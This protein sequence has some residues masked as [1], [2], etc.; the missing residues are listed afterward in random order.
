MKLNRKIL[1][2]TISILFVSLLISS[3]ALV[4]NFKKNYTE[5]LLS[6]S[7]GLGQ[8]LNS[9]VTELLNLGLPLDSFAGI[10]RK[11]RQLIA[12]NPHITY[13]G[14]TDPSGKVLYNGDPALVGHVFSDEV[15]ARSVASPTPI[16]Q[17]YHRFDGH[18]YYDVTIPIFDSAH[19]R[20][21]QIR[22]GFPISV[23]NDKILAALLQVVVNFSLSFV[24]IAVLINFFMS[25]FV[26]RPVIRI[27]EHA[28]KIADGN[29]D[30]EL[31]VTSDDEVGLLAGS[32]NQM[33]SQVKQKTR[34]L[35]AANAELQ[36]KLVERQRAEASLRASEEKFRTFVENSFDVIFVLDPAGV[37][38]FASPS[39]HKH[40]GFPASEVVGCDFRPF[41]HPDDAAPCVE[42]L[43]N[44]MATG[45][46]ATSPPY[47]VRHADGSWRLFIANG[48]CYTDPNGV[49]L[50]V[51][52]GRDI[53]DQKRAEEERLSLERNLL[54]T[55]KLESLG[56]LAG[57]I[58]HDFNNLLAAILGNLDLT[59]FRL[60]PASP[61]VAGITRAI[62][63]C[64]RASDLTQQM[65]AYSGKGVFQL[66]EI[67]LGRVVEENLELLRTT[68]PKAI[69]LTLD[70][71]N[72]L[73]LVNADPGQIQQVV[74]N[75]ITNASEAIGDAP[76]T[77]VVTTGVRECDESLLKRS[78]LPEKP[79][80]GRYASIEVSDSGC[81]MDQE[82]Q[83]R[84]FEPFFTTKFT[85][86]GLGM[87]AILGIIKAHNGA[88][89]MESEP[90]R[91]TTFTVLLPVSTEDRGIPREEAAPQ[92]PAEARPGFTGTVLVVDDE[93]VVREICVDYAGSF[94]FDTLSASDGVEAVELFRQHADA[95]VLVILDLTMPRMDGVATFRELKR[96]RPSVK[97]IASSGYA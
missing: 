67:D 16:T 22:L 54:H 63:A 75:L 94:G 66:K 73:P 40:F 45:Q 36:L 5:A 43:K 3:V 15:M 48:T 29:Y 35:E 78:R 64:R 92:E 27:S 50:Y 30:E 72:D 62:Q 60:D 77:I 56:V 31:P 20:L 38:Q 25:R 70:T 86:R 97:V 69:T 11:C 2:I 37:F 90:G 4:Y 96:I 71:T 44:V 53:S 79:P 32:V 88:I 7:Y 47:R 83:S 52:T 33:S 1:L 14:I 39:W 55:Q 51:G 89:L 24:V 81:G 76:G 26:S 80:P 46:G 57:G 17:L 74:M 19:T 93:P 8:S 65:L 23:V 10:D 34:D 87:S 49:R 9:V 28:R 13:V 82:T 42:Y 68:V 6:G 18:D 61:A 91:G 85:G 84:I 95:I 59:L 21:G 41:V 58:A 12:D